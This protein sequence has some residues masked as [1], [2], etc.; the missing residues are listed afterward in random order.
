LATISF[1]EVYN[2]F[3]LGEIRAVIEEC[4]VKH[5]MPKVKTI[6]SQETVMLNASGEKLSMRITLREETI[7]K[8]G[9]GFFQGQPR[10]KVEVVASSSEKGNLEETIDRFRYC[11]LIRTSR[12]GG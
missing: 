8:E 11:V 3:R 1:S 6:S 4:L 10:V 7:G 12:G 2:L 5:G 9:S